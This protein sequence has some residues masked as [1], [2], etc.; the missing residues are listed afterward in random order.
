MPVLTE[1]TFRCTSE[2]ELST[3]FVFHPAAC[4]CK[5]GVYDIHLLNQP[6]TTLQSALT[7]DY[8]RYSH[9]DGAWLAGFTSD[10][11]SFHLSNHFAVVDTAHAQD[12][13]T[14]TTLYRLFHLTVPSA[15][16][17]QRAGRVAT[18]PAL[19][20][21]RITQSL[22]TQSVSTGAPLCIHTVLTR[23]RRAS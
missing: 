23:I 20:S 10:F 2:G 6:A 7:K 16:L 1:G 5:F 4:L 14:Y 17:L 9:A 12:T 3:E 13:Y 21:C 8:V 15:M 11:A 19:M 18:G 22:L